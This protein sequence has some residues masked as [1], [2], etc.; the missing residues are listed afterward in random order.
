MFVKVALTLPCG[1]VFLSPLAGVCGKVE[2][3]PRCVKS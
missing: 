2:V 1:D 3:A